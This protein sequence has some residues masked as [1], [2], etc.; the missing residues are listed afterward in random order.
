MGAGKTCAAIATDR[1][2]TAGYLR[3]RHRLQHLRPTL[4]D[5][6]PFSPEHRAMHTTI[7]HVGLWSQPWFDAGSMASSLLR[8]RS[9]RRAD[10]AVRGLGLAVALLSWSRSDFRA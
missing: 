7:P 6:R 10:D 4:P 8:C 5:I 1:Q 2:R 3:L 9:L